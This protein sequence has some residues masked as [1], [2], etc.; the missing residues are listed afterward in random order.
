MCPIYAL[1]TQTQCAL[2]T[3]QQQRR[4]ERKKLSFDTHKHV[5]QNK[6]NNIKGLKISICP[7]FLQP[8]S[9]VAF[10]Q[11][12]PS[13]WVQCVS[14]WMSFT[15][16]KLSQ[17]DKTKKRTHTIR[18]HTHTIPS[19]TMPLTTGLVGICC[20]PKYWFQFVESLC[21]LYSGR[22]DYTNATTMYCDFILFFSFFHFCLLFLCDLF[23]LLFIS[24][25]WS[26]LFFLFTI[27]LVMFVLFCVIFFPYRRRKK[28]HKLQVNVRAIVSAFCST[29]PQH[30]RTIMV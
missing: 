11:Q 13:E 18:A 9:A 21:S 5:Q 23:C 19:N 27:F 16:E 12:R 10:V 28:R 25:C 2:H 17:N 6:K 7:F 15:W 20:Y 30:N 8:F 29:L 4:K 22:I 3:I 14:T 24:S 1:Y 26:V